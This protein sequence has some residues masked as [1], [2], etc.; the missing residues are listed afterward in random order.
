MNNMFSVERA[1]K[2]TELV[3]DWQNRK[4]VWGLFDC[5]YLA[6]DMAYR[7]TGNNLTKD[8]KPYSTKSGAIKSLKEF[9]FDNI[10][11]ALNDKFTKLNNFHE[12]GMGD[13]ISYKSKWKALPCLAVRTGA[14]TAIGF[15]PKIISQNDIEWDNIICY[16][17]PITLPDGTNLTTGDA[18]RIA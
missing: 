13:I 14:D 7:L 4:L 1:Q 3:T 5:V 8:I 6:C 10:N 9:G 12:S 11:E 17:M 2:V 16:V 15:M 18:W